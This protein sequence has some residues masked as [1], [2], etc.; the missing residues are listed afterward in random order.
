MTSSAQRPPS[1]FRSFLK[2]EASGGIALM[3]AAALG[4]I[5]ANSALAPAYFAVLKTYVAGLSIHHWI[6]DALMALF[7]LLVGL[8]IKREFLDGQLS[9]WSQR[10]LPGLAAV[11]GMVAP[12]LIYVAFNAGNPETLRG[13]AIPAATDIAFALGVLALLGKRVPLSLKVFLTAVAIIDD[14]LAVIVIALFYTEELSLFWLGLAGGA[15]LALVLLN[16]LKVMALLPYLL[17]GAVLW[18]LVLKSGVHATLAGVA[19]ALTIPLTPSPAA[20]D[21][22]DSPLHILEHALHPWVAFLVVP[23]FG[24]ANAGVSLAGMSWAALLAPVPIG[25]AAGLFLGKQVG[26]FGITWL[27]IR[28]GL[29]E[30]PARASF[31]QI[32][33]VALLAGIGFTMSLFI[34]MLAFDESEALQA[35]VKIGVLAG[36]LLSALCGAILLV[37][38]APK[39]RPG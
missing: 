23:V 39:P 12:A 11:G 13:W 4:L 30:K 2:G 27:A 18:F 5:V 32:Y 19:L 28:L 17:V 8:E 29:A 15:L 6:N 38:A 36:S 35:A 34:G 24:F 31:A 25:V 37:L 10:I 20:P 14:L 33:G 3:I 22:A 16:R 26:V 21:A 1:L 9:R 7:F